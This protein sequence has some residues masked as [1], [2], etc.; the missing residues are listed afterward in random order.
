M[1][2]PPGSNA[3]VPPAA[4]LLS[5][6][7]LTV[8]FGGLVAV[9]HVDF[10]VPRGAI[11]SLI[12]PNGAG[13]TTMFSMLG[14]F[15]RPTSG[16]IMFNG[17]EIQSLAPYEVSSRGIAR[18]FQITQAFPSLSAREVVVAAALVRN[19]PEQA[20]RLADGILSDM[21]LSARQ[22]VK[23]GDL[24]LAEQ[25][26]LE[27]ARALATGPRLILLD[28]ILGGLTP[29]EADDAIANI[30]RIRDS[31]VTVV[32]IEH[33]MRAMMALCDRILVL[34]AGEAISLGTP[35]EVSRDPLVI[36]AYLGGSE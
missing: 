23:S 12:G 21:A 35:L 29:R 24:T 5:V 26:R 1:T 16:A 34:D 6:D 18:T 20:S 3:G 14:G 8:R 11:V 17:A 4:P 7:R 33:M 10:D 9:S 19:S 28:E 32:I 2:H 30:R 25:R 27:I 36:A 13:K 22:D 31:G 15:A